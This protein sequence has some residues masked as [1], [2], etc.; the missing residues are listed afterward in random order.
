MKV[1]DLNLPESPRLTDDYRAKLLANQKKCNRTVCNMT[2]VTHLN[3]GTDAL[4]CTSCARKINEANP[5]I[6]IPLQPLIGTRFD[7]AANQLEV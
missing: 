6:C 1:S 2:R 7:L 5:G 3:T 4:Y